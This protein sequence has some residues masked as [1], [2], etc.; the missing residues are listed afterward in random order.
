M[1]LSRNQELELIE[2]ELEL[3]RRGGKGVVEKVGAAL[4]GV[5][6]PDASPGRAVGQA[7]GAPVRGIRGIAAGVEAATRGTPTLGDFDPSTGSFKLPPARPQP[8]TSLSEVTQAASEAVR[9]GFEAEGARQEIATGA[10]TLAAE[11]ALTAPVAAIGTGAALIRTA[12]AFIRGGVALAKGALTGATVTALD[13]AATDGDIQVKELIGPALIG[14]TLPI[15]G[16]SIRGAGRFMRGISRLFA[17]GSRTLSPE[18]AKFIEKTANI[19][20]KAQGDPKVIANIITD[21]QKK[22]IQVHK[23]VSEALNKTRAKIGITDKFKDASS[24]AGEPGF[25]PRTVPELE[26]ALSFLRG[27]GGRSLPKKEQLKALIE[28]RMDVNNLVRFRQGVSQLEQK[29]AP[30]QREKRFTARAVNIIDRTLRQSAEGREQLAAM[31]AWGESKN[32]HDVL[33]RKIASP[34]RAPRFLKALLRGDLSDTVEL[35]GSTLNL[36]RKLEKDSGTKFLGPLQKEFS[37][38]ALKE[39]ILTGPIGLPGETFEAE[40]VANILRTGALGSKGATAVGEAIDVP[41]VQATILALDKQRK[42]RQ[43]SR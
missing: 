9:P 28:L 43:R 40:G 21:M 24:V 42:N 36:L 22:T 34:D 30:A 32:M 23:G 8:S 13:Q 3:R 33:L 38:K 27:P 31:K 41:S 5:V 10:G 17:Q 7:I 15:I 1:A 39:S 37:V 19:V 12:P 11:I 25:V 6:S 26:N 16:V 14:A 2:I 18:E 35:K 4:P 20:N 29:I